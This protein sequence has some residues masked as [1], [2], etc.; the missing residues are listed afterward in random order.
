MLD[1]LK[2]KAADLIDRVVLFWHEWSWLV[3]I[4]LFIIALIALAQ[5]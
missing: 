1:K 5:L 2:S 4:V 3:A